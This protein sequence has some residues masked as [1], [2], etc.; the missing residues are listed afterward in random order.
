MC[1]KRSLRPEIPSIQPSAQPREQFQNETLRPILKLQNELLLA[2]YRHYLTKRKV[3][4]SSFSNQQLNEWIEQSVSKDNRLRGLLFG[5]VVGLFT[6]EEL[7]AY[8]A[9]ESEYNRRITSL[10]TQRFQD[11]LGPLRG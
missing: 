1:D 4:I 9:H 7:T 11:Q 3:P 5:M 6:D 8:L 10:L 2:L